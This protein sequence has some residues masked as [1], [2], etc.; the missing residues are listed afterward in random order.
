[1]KLQFIGT[2]TFA[3]KSRALTSF[4]INDE[5]LFDAGGGTV[6]GLQQYGA[7]FTK[8]KYIIITHFHIDHLP[9]VFNFLLR[10]KFTDLEGQPLTIVGPV[11]IEREVMDAMNKYM[12][13][14]FEAVKL[15]FVELTNDKVELDEY[16]II[17]HDAKHGFC[18]PANGYEIVAGD[19]H[20]GFSGDS[21]SC[22]GLDAIVQRSQALFLDSNG[23]GA[24]NDWHLNLDQALKYAQNFPDKKFYLVHRGDYE[25]PAGLPANVFAPDDGDVIEL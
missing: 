8:I 19:R 12:G 11:G 16:E 23:P 13:P 24:S 6:R 7:D 17:A 15:T 1:M 9:D 14:I 22:A 18:K 20:L 3:S 21:T 25:I 4:L 5:I 10:R 2:G